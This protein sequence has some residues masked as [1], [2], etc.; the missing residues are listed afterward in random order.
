M[1]ANSLDYRTPPHDPALLYAALYAGEIVR[2]SGL[3]EMAAV[4]TR[5]ADVRGGTARALAG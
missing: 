5:H 4:I 3:P 2:Y 1:P